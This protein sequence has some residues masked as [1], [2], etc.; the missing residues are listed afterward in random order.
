MHF[1]KFGFQDA[2]G[3]T[4]LHRAAAFGHTE[5][6]GS[7]CPL[8][9]AVLVLVQ[10][11]NCCAPSYLSRKKHDEHQVKRCQ[12]MKWPTCNILQPYSCNLTRLLQGQ[13]NTDEVPCSSWRRPHEET[14]NQ[15]QSWRQIQN[16]NLRIPILSC[17]IDGCSLNIPWRWFSG[18]KPIT[19]F[20]IKEVDSVDYIHPDAYVGFQ[21]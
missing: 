4:A 19:C 7:K 16:S 3:D 5:V 21:C 18:S 2:F 1:A 10:F 15:T 13:C 17:S 8:S 9:R 6:L 11:L 14:K 12:H 20:E